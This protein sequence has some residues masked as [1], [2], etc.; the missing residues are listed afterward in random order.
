M[1][2]YFT[3]DCHI[4]HFNAVRTCNRP[5]DTL[6]QMDETLINN[7]NKRV[8]KNDHVYIAGDLAWRGS[9]D[10]AIS[11]IKRL[12]GIKHLAV[13]NH[14]RFYLKNAEYY[15]LF[16]E[17]APMLYLNNSEGHIIVC[18]YPMA[19]WNKSRRGSWL[20]H[21]HIHNKRD[22]VY[23]FMATRDRALN[24]GVDVCGF[25]PVTFQ[26]LVAYNEAW[27]RGGLYE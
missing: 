11:K 25:M 1:S 12:K 9:V 24:A 19:E 7:W 8:H 22:D 26:E 3:A 10:S 27:K 14:D 4:G 2:I 16:E 5:F 17:I 18:H 20:V 23:D 6:E 13:G 15:A 21:G